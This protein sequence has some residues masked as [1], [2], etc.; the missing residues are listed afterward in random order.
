MAPDEM[1]KS[2]GIP[3]DSGPEEAADA[4]DAA[5]SAGSPDSDQDAKSYL[6]DEDELEALFSKAN[7]EDPVGAHEAESATASSDPDEAV[8]DSATEIV[9]GGDREGGVSSQSNQAGP[10]DDAPRSEESAPRTEDATPPSASVVLDSDAKGEEKQPEGNETPDEPDAE[11]APR[12]PRAARPA[13][14]ARLKNWMASW[15]L[16]FSAVNVGQL[17]KG[18]TAATVGLVTAMLVFAMLYMNHVR[19]ADPSVIAE[20]RAA[21]IGQ[22]MRFADNLMEL[23]RPAE[24]QAELASAIAQAPPSPLRIDARFLRIEAAV[25]ALPRQPDTAELEALHGE[26][27]ALLRAAQNHPRRLEAQFW[28]AQLYEMA[29]M[30]YAARALYERILTATPPVEPL[31]AVLYRAGNAALELNHGAEA[32]DL[33]RRLIQQHPES[34][35]ATQAHM[36]LGDAYLLAGRQSDAES[37]YRRTAQ[38]MADN[39][40]GA[41]ATKRLVHIAMEDSRY[42]DAAAALK[43]RLETATT[44][45]SND[46]LYLLL[47]KAQRAMNEYDQAEQTLREL[48]DF[49]PETRVTPIALVELANVLDAKGQRSEAVRLARR[50]ASQYEEPADALYE[51]GVFLQNTG[52]MEGAAM[53][54][55][56]AVQ[57]GSADAGT[58][59]A[60]GKAYYHLGE[61][62]SALDLLRRAEEAAPGQAEAFD[63]AVAIGRVYHDM[64]RVTDAVT[65]LQP[66]PQTAA[67][68]EQ[69]ADAL[70]ALGAVYLDL[71]LIEPAKTVYTQLSTL[72]D[73]SE[74]LAE[75]AIALLDARAWDQGLSVSNQVDTGRIPDQK[76]HQLIVLR[77]EALLRTDAAQGVA[78]L[79]EARDSYPDLW[80]ADNDL[81]LLRA[82]LGS[83]QTAAARELVG[84]L[85]NEAR[86]N[87][88]ATPP[89]QKATV[90]W[91]DF[92]YQR[93]DYRAAADAYAKTSAP[94]YEDTEDA[95]WAR[96]QRANALMQSMDYITSAELFHEL[97][98][99]DSPWADTAAVKAK[100]AETEGRLRGETEAPLGD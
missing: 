94:G 10:L 15:L 5:K 28:K 86:R 37:L 66:L 80:T 6:L 7:L 43:E 63:A 17:L 79:E 56:A 46:E 93:G 36:G 67:R 47:A 12:P 74:I 50:T 64:G 13:F 73:D 96:F 54:Y 38:A 3:E 45:E 20:A 16:D 62:E 91:G 77:G 52:D 70:N 49:F 97:A 84:E 8:G 87:P 75:A 23:G 42:E 76:A 55:S 40:M 26:I 71:G 82:Y 61:L 83:N 1:N 88:A 33:F 59:L 68:P 34:P 19:H 53:A 11:S 18:V 9:Y 100:Y 48:L 65:R 27:D 35:Y 29:D 90:R 89:F 14:V 95:E 78:L 31:D 2:D 30:H 41:E 24:A 99:S 57:D 4:Q 69:R 98:E 58:L 39:P 72:T 32:A 51:A 44:I 60:A 25:Q 22:A 85:E 81:A 21:D 92:L